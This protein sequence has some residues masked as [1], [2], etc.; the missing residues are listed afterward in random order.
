MNHHIFSP[1]QPIIHTYTPGDKS[2]H[3]FKKAYHT[4][5]NN[6][7]IIETEQ[8]VNKQLWYFEDCKCRKIYFTITK[9]IKRKE[10]NLEVKTVLDSLKSSPYIFKFF[11]DKKKLSLLMP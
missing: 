8:E 10:M 2:N 5:E 1:N 3:E 11:S 6:F 7:Q 4:W 9:N